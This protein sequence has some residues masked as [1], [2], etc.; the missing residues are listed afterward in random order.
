VSNK[1]YWID[2]FTQRAASVHKRNLKRFGT[3]MYNKCTQWKASL[4]HRSKKYGVPCTTTLEELLEMMYAFYGTPCKYCGK[5]LTMNT[6]AL[7]HIIPISK[8]GSSNIGNLQI[9]CRTSNG[10]KGSLDEAYF[11]M[12]LEWLQTVPEDM[13]KDISIRLSRGVR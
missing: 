12:L 2:I 11:Y 3:R 10:M 9:I 5:Q 1:Q 8:G 7:D 6:M 4:I 13:R